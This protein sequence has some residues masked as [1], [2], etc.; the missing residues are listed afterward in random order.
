MGDLAVQ[1]TRHSS[2]R[3]AAMFGRNAVGK[4]LGLGSG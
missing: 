4:F 3:Q 2:L 1:A